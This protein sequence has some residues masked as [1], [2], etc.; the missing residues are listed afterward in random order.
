METNHIACKHQEMV[1]SCPTKLCIN[2]PYPIQL[3]EKCSDRTLHLHFMRK[4]YDH[5]VIIYTVPWV[6]F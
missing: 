1:S 4:H 5:I 3:S 6:S 2:L